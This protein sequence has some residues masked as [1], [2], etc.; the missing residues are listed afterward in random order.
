MLVQNSAATRIWGM[1]KRIPRQ[2]AII[3]EVAEDRDVKD[4]VDDGS[5]GQYRPGV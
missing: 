4:A 2:L 5:A 3:E 1:M